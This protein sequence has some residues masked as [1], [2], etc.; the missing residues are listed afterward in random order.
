MRGE[1]INTPYISLFLH[2]GGGGCGVR[3]PQDGSTLQAAVLRQRRHI[4]YNPPNFNQ[5]LRLT[6][7][8]ERF[9]QIRTSP[10]LRDTNLPMRDQ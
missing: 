7:E 1:Q 3:G 5:P 9:D 4:A 6:D 2:L 10:K 8:N